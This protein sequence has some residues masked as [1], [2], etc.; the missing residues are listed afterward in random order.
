MPRLLL[1][2]ERVKRVNY[3]TLRDGLRLIPELSEEQQKTHSLSQLNY[4]NLTSNPDFPREV[5]AKVLVKAYH[6]I[7][8][9]I[10]SPL[11]VLKDANKTL[12]D[13]AQFI[14]DNHVKRFE[15]DVADGTN[16]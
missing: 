6:V 13:L 11:D 14:K 3:S 2:L 12:G 16:A 1:S 4:A 10:V 7:G 8:Y 9:T 15:D 5:T